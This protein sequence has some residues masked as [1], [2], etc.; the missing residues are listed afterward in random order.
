MIQGY[1]VTITFLLSFCIILSVLYKRRKA[2]VEV[3]EVKARH[4]KS[5]SEYIERINRV[6]NSMDGQEALEI[7]KTMSDEVKATVFSGLDRKTVEIFNILANG[8]I[9]PFQP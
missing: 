5:V 1:L 2:E 7:R 6:V 4:Y 9:N 3:F 8:G